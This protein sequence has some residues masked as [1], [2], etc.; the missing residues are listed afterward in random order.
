SEE[1]RCEMEALRLYD[2]KGIVRLIDA[3]TEQGAMLLERLRPGTP[4]SLV[5]DDVEATHVAAQVMRQLWRPLPDEHSFPTVARW[6][7]GLGRLRAEFDGGTGPFPRA[8]VERAES[9]FIDLLASSGEPVLL[10]GDLHYDNIVAGMREPWLA[11]DP[12]GLVGEPEYEVGALMRNRLPSPL[13]GAE[14]TWLLSARLSQLAEE[15]NFSCER[16]H[17]WSFA[18]AVLSAWWSYED[19]GHGWE[20]AVACAEALAVV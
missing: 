18:Q 6:A 5:E 12:K 4:L 1:L 15:L 19:H 2:G 16:L 10:H 9:L 17:A 3:D 20:K 7:L 11:L 14:A 13:Q 8:L